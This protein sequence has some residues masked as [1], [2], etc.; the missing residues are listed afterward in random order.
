MRIKVSK[1]KNKNFD[2]IFDGER[3]NPQQEISF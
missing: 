3:S 1:K 2:L